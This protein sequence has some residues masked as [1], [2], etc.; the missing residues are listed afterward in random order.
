MTGQKFD[1]A[2]ICRIAHKYDI[3]V[4]LDLAHGLGNVELKLN[5]WNVDCATFCGYKYLCGSGGGIGGIFVHKMHHNNQEILNRRLQGWWGQNM[6]DILKFVPDYKHAIGARAWGISQA[7][8]FECVALESALEIFNEAGWNNLLIK[9]K[10]LTKYL[11]ILILRF[12]DKNDIK[13]V[14]PLNENERG[15]QL[16]LEI[17]DRNNCKELK[18]W[19]RDKGVICYISVDHGILRVA[20]V[21][22]YNRFSEC[23]DFVQILKGYFGRKHKS[24][25]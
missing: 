15:C 18:R 6:E 12:I 13:I 4:G 25:L 16:A 9:S 17:I 2:R 8:F 22:L 24:K 10:R 1:I 19:L 21:P 5:E 20:P 14:T 3:Y 7:S 11:E 23:W